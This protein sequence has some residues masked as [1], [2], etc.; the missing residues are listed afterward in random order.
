[1][2]RTELL[3]LGISLAKIF[4]QDYVLCYD[5]GYADAELSGRV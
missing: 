4:T 5:K 2:R 1:M 3:F